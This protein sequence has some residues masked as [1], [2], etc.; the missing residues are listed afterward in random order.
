MAGV[1][2]NSGAIV[3]ELSTVGNSEFRLRYDG[4]RLL[5]D[6]V[7]ESY[8]LDIGTQGFDI[9]TQGFDISSQGFDIDSHGFQTD[10][11]LHLT[12]LQAWY[13]SL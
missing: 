12:S 7:G 11:L 6:G 9:G 4:A 8:K 1:A 3:G 10:Q 2:E 13:P 5:N